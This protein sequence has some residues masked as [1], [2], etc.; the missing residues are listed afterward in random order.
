MEVTGL[1]LVCG[2]SSSKVSYMLG[3]RVQG[4]GFRASVSGWG[5]RA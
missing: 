4:L 2:P 1:E 3:F 5:F